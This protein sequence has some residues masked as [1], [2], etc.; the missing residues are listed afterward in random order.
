MK[1]DDISRWTRARNEG[2][3]LVESH[4]SSRVRHENVNSDGSITHVEGLSADGKTV[5][6]LIRG[7]LEK[8]RHKSDGRITRGPIG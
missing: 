6:L 2:L 3:N 4:V 8:R 1:L 5:L 7:E